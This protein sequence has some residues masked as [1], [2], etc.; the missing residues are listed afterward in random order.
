MENKSI[1][2]D[3]EIATALSG[4][5]GSR[6]DGVFLKKDFDFANFPVTD[7]QA[8]E[9]QGEQQAAIFDGQSLDGWF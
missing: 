5:E 3:E 9:Q 4:C 7:Q 6:R 2:T 1:L 8:L